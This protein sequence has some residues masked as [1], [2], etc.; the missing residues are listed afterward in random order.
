MIGII[1]TILTVSSILPQLYKTF[2][3]KQVDHLS[4]T[5][6]LVLYIGL[7]CWLLYG[8]QIDNFA[9]IIANGISLTLQTLLIWMKLRYTEKTQ[10]AYVLLL[11]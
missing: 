9:V 11:D 1:A 4:L 3:S 10:T 5:Q 2:K 8:V 6:M 7:L